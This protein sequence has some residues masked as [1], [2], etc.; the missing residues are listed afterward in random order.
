MVI[1]H[2]S[3]GAAYPDDLKLLKVIYDEICDKRGLRRG[4]AAAEQLAVVTM[5]LFSK[6]V[7]DEAEIRE[8][9]RLFLERKELRN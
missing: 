5:E 2:S 6:G 9:L 7:L 4:S 8:S 3:S 1:S